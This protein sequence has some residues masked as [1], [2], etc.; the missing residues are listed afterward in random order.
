MTD[1]H[2]HEVRSYNMSRIK[3]RDT[4]PE[5]LIRSLVHRLGYRFRLHRKDL[6]GKPDLVFPERKKVIFVHGCYWHVHDCPFGAVKPAT[7]AFF[8]SEKRNG[9]VL[10]DKLNEAKLATLGWEALTIWECE[11]KNTTSVAKRIKK[12][13]DS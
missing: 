4:K 2:T 3:S 7:N 6:P 1:V 12:F 11:I 10:R 8:W 13:L 5:L 9:N